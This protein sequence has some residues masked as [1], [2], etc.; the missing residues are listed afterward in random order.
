MPFF[1]STL[2]EKDLLAGCIRNERRKQELLY[3]QYCQS[4]LALCITYTKSEEDAHEILQDGFLKIFQKI[5]SY[6]GSKSSLYTWMR[7][8]MIRTAIDFLRRHKSEIQTIEIDEVNEPVS[9]T[10]TIDKISNRELLNYLQLLPETTRTV[11]NLFITEG[12]S[13]K[14]IG[15]YLNIS[16]GTSRWH[17]SEARK[18]CSNHL[19]N[20]L[21]A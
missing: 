19:K 14:E 9:D 7:T 6:D 4:M 21:T 16:E 1:K 10:G 5:N 11:F 8:V 18:F 2:S 3:K 12:Y 15:A 17:L 13:H 20:K